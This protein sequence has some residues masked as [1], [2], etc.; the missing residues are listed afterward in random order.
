MSDKPAPTPINLLG[1]LQDLCRQ[2]S[3][4][5]LTVADVKQSLASLPLK[6]VVERAPGSTA[7]G[8]VRIALP[9]NAHL[10]LEELE[11]VFGPANELPGLHRCAPL[12]YLITV[13]TPGAPYTCA[14]LIEKRDEAPF[15]EAVTVRRDIRLS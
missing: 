13:D 1:T 7:P 3:R 14:L 9:T 2:L 6:A 5:P 15:V 11:S 12:E 10:T 8:F 4:D